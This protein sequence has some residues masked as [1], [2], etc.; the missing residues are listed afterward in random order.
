MC[1]VKKVGLIINPIAG[2]G[3]KAGLKGSDGEATQK[4]ALA[5]GIKPESPDKAMIALETMQELKGKIEI[6]TDFK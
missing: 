4:E 6:Y 3:G 2:V 1:G 5:K